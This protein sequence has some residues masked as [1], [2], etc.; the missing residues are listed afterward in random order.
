[1]KQD[2][3][4]IKTEKAIHEAFHQLL[5]EKNVQ[6]ITVRDIS[7]RALINKTTFYSHYPTMEDFLHSLEEETISSVLE[8]VSEC[9]LLFQDPERFVR[10]LYQGLSEYHTVGKNLP[11]GITSSFGR[12]LNRAVEEKLIQQDI[13]VT[14][15][16]NIG[17]LVSFL[18]SGLMSILEEENSHSET[19][20]DFLC[21]F[22]KGGIRELTG[23]PALLDPE[24]KKGL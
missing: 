16:G 13:D 11:Y 21:V 8:Q 4:Y 9:S 7:Q 24:I 15:Y 3:R 14:R 12:A 1:M 18:I 5:K 2:L 10:Q 6:K 22:V 20:L 23:N 19:Q 17:T